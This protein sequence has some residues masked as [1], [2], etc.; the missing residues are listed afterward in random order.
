VRF[1]V[2]FPV[3]AKDYEQYNELRNLL[4]EV[5]KKHSALVETVTIDARSV[6]GGYSHRRS[7][8]KGQAAGNP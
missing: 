4:D 1:T 2:S 8:K 5:G 6:E 7:V 3:F